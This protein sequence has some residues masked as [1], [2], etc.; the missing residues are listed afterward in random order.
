MKDVIEG[1]I[2]RINR[3]TEQYKEKLVE[4][5]IIPLLMGMLDH[6][7]YILT[8]NG[9]SSL[10]VRVDGKDYLREEDPRIHR[11]TME[12]SIEEADEIWDEEQE[13]FNDNYGYK[14]A[15]VENLDLDDYLP[16]YIYH[17]RIE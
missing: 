8:G 12:M 17:D 11:D 10:W 16:E 14:M 6:D 7:E 1:E 4:E 3:M 9:V 13:A 15:I 2:N 5:M